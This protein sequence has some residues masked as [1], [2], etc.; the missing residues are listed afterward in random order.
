V[1]GADLQDGLEAEQQAAPGVRVRVRLVQDGGNVFEVAF[2]DNR[3][4]QVVLAGVVPVQRRRSALTPAR[5]NASTDSALS[6]LPGSAESSLPLMG[7]P[8]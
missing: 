5:R 3:R 6:L 7:A 2:A 8:R 1:L 4:D